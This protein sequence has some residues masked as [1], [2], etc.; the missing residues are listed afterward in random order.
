MAIPILN[1][2]ER[3]I[4]EHGSSVILKEHLSLLN[5]KLGLLKEDIERLQKEN[6]YLIKR[7][8]YL[9]QEISRQNK[10][11]EFVESRG[12]LFKPL[13]GGGYE[14]TPSYPVCHS[15]MWAFERMFPYEC[16]N[17]SC[18][19]TAGFNGGDLAAVMEKLP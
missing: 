10:A 17:Q 7:N 6:A 3:I 13:A 18:K 16:G 19:R 1:E 2:I 12:A 9:E 5:T 14:E 8:D 11:Q 15:A 4:N